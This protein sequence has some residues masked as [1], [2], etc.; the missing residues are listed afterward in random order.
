MDQ[1]VI[2]GREPVTLDEIVRVAEKAKAVVAKVRKVMLAPTA[3]K[4]APL[5][6]MA[7]LAAITGLDTRQIEYRVKKGDLPSGRLNAAG[8]R[9]EFTL[10]EV[11]KWSREIRRDRMRPPGA[12]ALTLSIGNFKGGVAKTTTAITLAQGLSLL[13]HRVLLI[14]TDPQGSLT[15]LF[16]VLPDAEVEK[17][18]TILP[19]CEGTETD[20]RY[21]IR[22]TY[23]DGIDLVASAALLFSAE[24]LLPS[25]QKS[26]PNFEF[27]N[28]LHYAIDAARLEYDVIIIDTPPALSYVTINVFMASNGIIMPLPPNA[29]DFASSAQF[30]D[31]FAD[32]T[33]S[34][35]AAGRL[36]KEFDFIN[37]LLSRVDVS[38]AASAVV[39]EWISAAYG[40][41][42]LPVEVPKTSAAATASAEFGS[43][44]DIRPGSASNKTIKRAVEAYDRVVEQIEHQI[45]ATWMKQTGG[46]A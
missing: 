3:A 45:V 7:Q 44:Y 1:L 10:A 33:G 46:K 41:K 43:I 14:D 12:E 39:R 20:I 18:D 21:A 9:R 38:D 31:L 8:S 4:E 40:E 11:R 22:P 29:L 5:Y 34:L 2:Q 6:N 28:V 25:R 23:W 37:V 17:N 26:E 42:V 13:G 15:T 32:L 16:G 27:W 36:S 24:F 19:L 30:W 35:A